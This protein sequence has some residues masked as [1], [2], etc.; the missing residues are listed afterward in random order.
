MRKPN[1]RGWIFTK[2]KAIY[3]HEGNPIY[4][5]IYGVSKTCVDY[6]IANNLTLI[7]KTKHGIATY[8]NP[9]DFLKGTTIIKKVHYYPNNP[10]LFYKKDLLPDIKAREM[11][12]KIEKKMEETNGQLMIKWLQKLKEKSPDEFNKLKGQLTLL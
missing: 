2:N 10:I 1:Y 12:K 3:N 11:R 6:A 5:T 4:G 7:I 8:D 9:R